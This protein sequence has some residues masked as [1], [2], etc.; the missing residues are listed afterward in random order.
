RSQL[1]GCPHR[2]MGS[3]DQCVPSPDWGDDYHIGGCVSYP[4]TA[5]RGRGNVLGRFGDGDGQRP[6]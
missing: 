1:D 2:E 6:T 4:S 3:D 5:D